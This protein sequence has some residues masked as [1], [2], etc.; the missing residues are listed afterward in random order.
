LLVRNE[1][2]PA[3]S[4]WNEQIKLIFTVV[5]TVVFA[6]VW[7]WER[8]VNEKIRRENESL[9]AILEQLKQSQIQGEPA[10]GRDS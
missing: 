8:G 10:S 6:S 4:E 2:V 9:R 1:L 5:A 3:V 7:Q